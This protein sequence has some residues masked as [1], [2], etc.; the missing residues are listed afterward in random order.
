MRSASNQKMRPMKSLFYFALLTGIVS[1][2]TGFTGRIEPLNG[3]P[4]S[5]FS[6]SLDQPDEIHILPSQL[7]EV[8]GLTD[9]SATEIA[10]VQDEQGVIFTYNLVSKATGP[11]IT[12]A[13]DGDYEGLTRVHDILFALSSEGTLYEVKPSRG[14]P[15]TEIYTLGLTTPD[16]EG[17]CYDEEE[18]RLLIAPKSKLGKGPEYKDARAIFV[19]DLKKRKMEKEPLFYYNVSDIYAY[20]TE[21]DLPVHQPYKKNGTA[22]KHPNFRPSSLSVHPLTQEIYVISAEDFCLV[23]FDKEGTITGFTSLDPGIFSKP[24]GLT[25]FP[26]GTMVVTNEGVAGEPTAVVFNPKGQ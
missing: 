21:H 3:Q 6:Y 18:N 7:T 1:L 8:S 14:K 4:K 2:F 26:D 24:E 17:L 16:N 25:F 19:F 5:A 13:A 12:F 10:C 23:V 22:S 15:E 11:E 9:L 20:A